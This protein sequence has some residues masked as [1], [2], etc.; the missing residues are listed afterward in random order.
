M[1]IKKNIYWF[2]HWWYSF[3]ILDTLA[4]IKAREI[5]WDAMTTSASINFFKPILVEEF[6]DFKKEIVVISESSSSVTMNW[7][8]KKDEIIY[9]SATFTFLKIKKS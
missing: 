6:D 9:V 7:F 5:L 8:L 1:I 4:W 2:M 3:S